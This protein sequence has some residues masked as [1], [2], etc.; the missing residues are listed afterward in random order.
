MMWGDQPLAATLRVHLTAPCSALRDAIVR[1][2]QAFEA[3]AG[4]SDDITLLVARRG[5]LAP[6]ELSDQPSASA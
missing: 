6:R 2:V 4:Q 3:G 5:T 1:E